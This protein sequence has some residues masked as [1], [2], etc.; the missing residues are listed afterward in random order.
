MTDVNP[1]E[2]VPKNELESGVEHLS[3]KTEEPET[4]ITGKLRCMYK[5]KPYGAEFASQ[6]DFK[7]IIGG[8]YESTTQERT[9]DA[10]ALSKDVREMA[11][12]AGEEEIIHVIDEGTLKAETKANVGIGGA[13]KLQDF[14]IDLTSQNALLEGNKVNGL[15][16]FNDVSRSVIVQ[17]NKGVF[18]SAK[19]NPAFENKPYNESKDC[20]IISSAD[21]QELSSILK[22]LEAQ[23]KYKVLSRSGDVLMTYLN[24]MVVP[25]VCWDEG[26]W[27]AEE[28]KEADIVPI[29]RDKKSTKPVAEPDEEQK[30]A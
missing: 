16:K 10:N 14:F 8:I 9:E 22:E 23:G 26:V 5:G 25:F 29:N 7:K 24:G 19:L 17:D 18:E 20:F 15:C 27:D 28:K 1:G 11:P 3:T 30:A 21:A 12:A 4:S 6:N 13:K 2:V